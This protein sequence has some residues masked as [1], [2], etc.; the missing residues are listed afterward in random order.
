MNRQDKTGLLSHGRH[1]SA[2]LII[3][4]KV[5]IIALVLVLPSGLAISLGAAHVVAIVLVAVSLA[6]LMIVRH[7]RNRSHK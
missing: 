2:A 3:A 4:V 1:R 5:A 7:L 6:A